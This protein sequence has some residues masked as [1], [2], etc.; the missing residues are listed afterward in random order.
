MTRRARYGAFLL[1]Q[2]TGFLDGLLKIVSSNIKSGFFYRNWY[3]PLIHRIDT[4]QGM[5][6]LGQIAPS[7]P[8]L[9]LNKHHKYAS[10]IFKLF[11][12]KARHL[13]HNALRS[14]CF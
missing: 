3:L 12:R 7:K 8:I 14:I 1:L 13:H 11:C 10:W 5:P 4:L 2:E 9:K 6:Y